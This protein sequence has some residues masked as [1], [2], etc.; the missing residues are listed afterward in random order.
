MRYVFDEKT[1]EYRDLDPQPEQPEQHD[2]YLEIYQEKSG[3]WGY[4]LKIDREKYNFLGY[5]GQDPAA[6][7]AANRLLSVIRGREEVYNRAAGQERGD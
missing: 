6:K 7:A 4:S 3:I 5:K 1:G 2:I